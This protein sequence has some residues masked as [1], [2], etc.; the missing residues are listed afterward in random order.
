MSESSS[1]LGRERRVRLDGECK[2]HVPRFDE[3]SVSK[4]ETGRF[5]RDWLGSYKDYVQ[6]HWAWTL[7]L[8]YLLSLVYILLKLVLNPNC[9]PGLQ[10]TLRFEADVPLPGRSASERLAFAK[11]WYSTAPRE[12]PFDGWAVPARFTY[13]PD[14]SMWM[15]RFAFFRWL[16]LP[17]QCAMA[18]FDE[19]LEQWH[20]NSPWWG[21]HLLVGWVIVGENPDN[22]GWL[23]TGEFKCWCF[24]VP[25]YKWMTVRALGPYGDWIV[26]AQQ[27]TGTE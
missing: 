23:I 21:P 22:T 25:V 17:P 4:M 8:Y 7:P 20:L 16:V 12:P 13:L 9:L 19:S 27:A 10:H 3:A 11:R 18:R 2:F 1:F 26:E 6:M 5:W 24:L 15:E 14:R